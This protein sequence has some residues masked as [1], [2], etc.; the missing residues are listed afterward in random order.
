MTLNDA[1]AKLEWTLVGNP[2]TAFRHMWWDFYQGL[3]KLLTGKS[4]IYEFDFGFE[5]VKEIYPKYLQFYNGVKRNQHAYPGDLNSMEEW[6]AILDEI[7]FAFEYTIVEDDDNR[8]AFRFYKKWGLENP[9]EKIE[10]NR[11]KTHFYRDDYELYYN[12]KLAMKYGERRMKGF[13]L[14]GKYL[15]GMW[16]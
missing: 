16:T 13:E 2:K 7:L 4:L 12:V 11:T 5:M 3:R 1:L 9:H 10:K 6:I 8:K 15:L 14:F